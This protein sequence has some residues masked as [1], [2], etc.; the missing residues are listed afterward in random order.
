M[1][2]QP[3]S[4]FL[5]DDA[6]C[7]IRWRYCRRQLSLQQRSEQTR[8]GTG[9]A[10]EVAK[11]YPELVSFDADGKPQTVRYLELSAML[12]NELQTQ[13]KENQRQAG[14]IQHQAHENQWLS[15]QVAQLK[16]MFE[17][18]LEAQRDSRSLVAAFNR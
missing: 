17:Q 10:E 1:N 2:E 3:G 4:R 15:A 7:L 14:Q 13:A 5:E 16:G 18:A 9:L 6:T 11:G 8:C 12:L